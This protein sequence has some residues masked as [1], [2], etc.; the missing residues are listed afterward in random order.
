[1]VNNFEVLKDFNELRDFA[2]SMS[3]NNIC[4]HKDKVRTCFDIIPPSQM[5]DECRK[6]WLDFLTSDEG[7][8]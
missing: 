8:K 2:I 4:C 5:R 6:C 7:I 1:M 3:K